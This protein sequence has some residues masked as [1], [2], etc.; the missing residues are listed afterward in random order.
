MKRLHLLVLVFFL[1]WGAVHAAESSSPKDGA[2]EPLFERHVRPILKAHCFH[3][4]GELGETQGGL[5]LRLRRFLVAGGDSGPA[6]VPGKPDESYLV[7]RI[8]SQEMPP[9]EAKMPAEELAIIERWVA[10]G[11]KTAR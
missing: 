8:R 5:D 4:H 6:I 3:C 10:A 7:A 11:A 1:P 2:E 9:G